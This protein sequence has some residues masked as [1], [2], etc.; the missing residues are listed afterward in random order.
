M[1]VQTELSP[2]ERVALGAAYLDTVEPPWVWRIDLEKL[3][4]REGRRRYFSDPGCVLCQLNGFDW[5]YG[6]IH[7]K[8]GAVF[9]LGFTAIEDEWAELQ[10]AWV[11]EITKRR[12]G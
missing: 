1:S 11:D 10:E 7:Y 3:D 4:I 9:E 12:A 5:A 6:L 8:V 2:A